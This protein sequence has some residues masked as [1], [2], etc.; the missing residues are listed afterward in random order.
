MAAM[1]WRLADPVWRWVGV[2]S[3]L[4]LLLVIW[5]SFVPL[6]V[7][8]VFLFTYTGSIVGGRRSAQMNALKAE[9]R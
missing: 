4:G 1:W 6:L 9:Q 2:A 8:S 5:T 7:G 3:A